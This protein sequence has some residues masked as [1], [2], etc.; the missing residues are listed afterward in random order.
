MSRLQKMLDHTHFLFLPYKGNGSLE[1]LNF[2]VHF[3]ITFNI[4]LKMTEGVLYQVA[5]SSRDGQLKTGASIIS[6]LQSHAR[7]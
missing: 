7:V 6:V 3:Q 2:D 1:F 4:L 5:T